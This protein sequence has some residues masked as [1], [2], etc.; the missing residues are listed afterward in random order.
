MKKKILAMYKLNYEEQM[1][2]L[3]ERFEIVSVK[4][5][6]E[7]Q[8]V[9]DEN[10]DHIVAILGVIGRKISGNLIKALP[11]LEIISSFGVGTDH[12][13][14]ET[15]KER[16]IIVTNTPDVVTRDTADTAMALLL[17]TSRRIVEADLYVRLGKWLQGS[18][19]LGNALWGKTIGILGLGNIGK[20]IAKRAAAFDMKVAYTARS[21]KPDQPYTFYKTAVSLA[22]A[23]DYLVV[24]TPGGN[25]TKHLVNKEVLEALGPDGTLINIARGSVVDEVALIEALELGKIKRAGLD[26]YADEPHVPEQLIQMDQVVLLPHIGTATYETRHAQGEMVL[27]NLEAYFSGKPLISRVV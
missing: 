11:N 2:R 12:I 19:P 13:D 1:A 15:A 7:A 8:S 26:V 25:E 18:M 9:I 6:E 17:A 22:K 16:E 4:S 24:A 10:R 20:E 14:L 3:D 27:A 5:A 23:S 21:E